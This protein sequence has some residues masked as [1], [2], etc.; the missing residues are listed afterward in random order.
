MSKGKS[1]LAGFFIGGVASAITTLLYTPSSGK[2]LRKR[3]KTQSL[4]WKRLADQLMQ[5]GLRLKDQIARTSKEGV[6]LM[7]HLTQE[8]K[9]SVEEWKSA[10]EPHQENIHGYLEEI[11]S[12][13]KDLEK[14]I[15]DR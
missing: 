12:S 10:V 2:D 4:E 9:K 8:M 5:D 15:K 3:I 11:E 14:K 7:G 1:F 13:L 6:A